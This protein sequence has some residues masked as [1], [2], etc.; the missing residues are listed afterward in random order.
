MKILKQT[1]KSLL[2]LALMA[3][4]GSSLASAQATATPVQ[5]SGT[6]ADAGA[7]CA[8][9]S[10]STG[11]LTFTVPVGLSFYLTYY[12]IS[13]VAGSSAVTAA[14]ATTITTTGFGGTFT[15]LMASGTT[16]GGAVQN[17]VSPA[18][19][20]LKGSQS[21]NVVFTLPTFA[22]NQTIGMAA[23]GYLAP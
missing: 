11:T 13:N 16:A 9:S 1:L 3:V 14:T 19:L 18:G 7:I 15:F 17:F 5:Q 20:A 4:L 12:H 10:T 21:T 2:V 8:Y 6:K 23:C 22:T